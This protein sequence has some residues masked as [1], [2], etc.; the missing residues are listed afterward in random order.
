M[1]STTTVLDLLLEM[2]GVW[3]DHLEAFHPNGEPM[4]DD[5]YGGAPGPFPYDNL[6]YCDVDRST[7]RYLQ[8]NVTFQGRPLKVRSFT[9]QIGDDGLLRFD[10]LGRD[11]PGHVGV[12][13][14][15]GV[16]WFTPDTTTHPGLAKFSEPDHIRLLGAGQRTRVTTL[17]RSGRL[18]RTM[19]VAGSKVADDP[20]VRVAWD[21]RGT[22]GPVHEPPKPTQVF[23]SD[24]G[25]NG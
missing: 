5:P 6:V 1:I 14:G 12:S 13:G 8:T 17:F 9:A 7:G 20:T 22:D 10:R 4:G 23:V 18:V 15:P 11:D 24:T 2:R 21:P 3:V 16:L 25:T 19:T